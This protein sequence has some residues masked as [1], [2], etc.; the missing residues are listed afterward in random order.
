MLF[1]LSAFL[2]ALIS[3]SKPAH[4][5]FDVCNR[6][7]QQVSVA[8][9]YMDKQPSVPDI[10]GSRTPTPNGSWNSQGWW[11]LTSGECA[12]VYPHQ[13]NHRNTI[14]YVYAKSQDGTTVW[15][16]KQTFCVVPSSGFHLSAADHRC[17][18]KGEWR[19]FIEVSTGNS[20][21]YTVPL[22]E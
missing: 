4:A 20:K 16:G 18:G 17:G 12:R 11:S 15:S 14:Y 19:G 22:T 6:S 13:L 21:N 9:A 5:W 3:D 10:F 8:F 7:T 2:I 1:G